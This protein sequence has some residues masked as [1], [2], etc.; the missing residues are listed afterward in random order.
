MQFNKFEDM[1]DFRRIIQEKKEEKI[2]DLQAVNNHS[3]NDGKKRIQ[4]FKD[5]DELELLLMSI[6]NI[7]TKCSKF[8]TKGFTI[9]ITKFLNMTDDKTDYHLIEVKTKEQPKIVDKIMAR[10]AK[11]INNK[12]IK[13]KS[14]T[15]YVIVGRKKD[16]HNNESEQVLVLDTY[17]ENPFN[18]NFTLKKEYSKLAELEKAIHQ[19]IEIKLKDSETSDRKRYRIVLEKFEKKEKTYKK[20]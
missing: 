15:K 10:V 17:Y 20:M 19:L 8:E 16:N 7:L 18:N 5:L 2:S 9:F 13:I 3:W 14:S 4:I 12:Q 6:D 1:I 11:K